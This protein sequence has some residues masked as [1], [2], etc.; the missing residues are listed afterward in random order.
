MNTDV[1]MTLIPQSKHFTHVDRS[2]TSHRTDLRVLS[3]WQPWATLLVHGKKTIE[4]RP[5]AHQY[6]GMFLVH[7]SKPWNQQC[8]TEACSNAHIENALREL[9]YSSPFAVGFASAVGKSWNDLPRGAVIG[10]V[11]LIDCKPSEDLV[12]TINDAEM[13]MGNYEPGRYGWIC[14]RFTPFKTPVPMPGE[15]SLFYLKTDYEAAVREQMGAVVGPAH[16][17]I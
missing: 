11:D 12:N 17:G 7:A 3:I 1:R 8:Q 6:R 10:M 15:Q 2:A 4:T 13:S 16:V 9:G 14:S 5:M